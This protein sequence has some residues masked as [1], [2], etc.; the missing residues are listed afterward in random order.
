MSKNNLRHAEHSEILDAFL[1]AKSKTI[2]NLIKIWRLTNVKRRIIAAMLTLT[3]LFSSACGQT[4][5]NVTH[6]HETEQ[7]IKPTV[8]TEIKSEKEHKE[9]ITVTSQLELDLALVNNYKTITIDIDNYDSL[10]ISEDKYDTELIISAPESDILNFGAF[11]SVTIIGDEIENVDNESF[12]SS[13][14]I[15][16]EY[17]NYNTISVSGIGKTYIINPIDHLIKVDIEKENTV[18]T[19]DVSG[20]LETLNI[21]TTST[22]TV[23]VRATEGISIKPI[24]IDAPNV[25]FD[26]RA[27]NPSLLEPIPIYVSELS[28]G[29]NITTNIPVTIYTDAEISVIFERGAENSNIIAKDGIKV[30]V[31]NK[32]ASDIFVNN[33]KVETELDEETLTVLPIE[34]LPAIPGTEKDDTEE[35]EENNTE[36]RGSSE[37][38]G[39]VTIVPSVPDEEPDKHTHKYNQLDKDTATCTADGVKI[40]SCSCGATVT[41]ISIR[42]GHSFNG[43]TCSVCGLTCSH[44]N[45]TVTGKTGTD[46][47]GYQIHYKKCTLCSNEISERC[48]FGSNGNC[49]ICNTVCKHTNMVTVSENDNTHSNSCAVCG[50][51]VSSSHNYSAVGSDDSKHSYTCADCYHTKNESHSFSNGRCSVCNYECSHFGVGFTGCS[52]TEHSG[53]CSNCSMTVTKPHDWEVVTEYCSTCMYRCDH[54]GYE[55]LLE[56]LDGGILKMKCQNCGREYVK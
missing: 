1:F 4:E 3:L 6:E 25:K 8:E 54:A 34:P 16:T 40:Y 50:Y 17:N 21:D 47:N 55:I 23:Y 29:S 35:D 11:N 43:N 51:A 18:S 28:E 38:E 48:S 44:Q 42:K 33:K 5:N 30:D 13:Q 9:C 19:I 15:W 31:T 32:T 56:T 49:K 46:N 2:F 37:T 53:I 14:N 12:A 45:T 36:N 10:V 39:T 24:Y 52:Y 27:E 26:L 41:E 20:V 7:V 22:V